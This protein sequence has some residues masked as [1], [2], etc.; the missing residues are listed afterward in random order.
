MMKTKLNMPHIKELIAHV[1]NG[2]DDEELGNIFNIAPETAA[3][4]RK[5][6]CSPPEPEVIEDDEDD[7][8]APAKKSR[9]KKAP[10]RKRK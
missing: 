7:A 1:E 9:A 3:H 4:Y 6:F 2:K 10:A 5:S 8:P